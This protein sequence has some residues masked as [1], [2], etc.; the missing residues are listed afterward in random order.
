[1]P[2]TT[3]DVIGESK[4]VVTG[5]KFD[6]FMKTFW[7]LLITF[8]ALPVVAQ[9]TEP[10]IATATGFKFTAADLPAETAE[11]YRGLSTKIAELRLR[12]LDEE[13]ANTLFELEAKS[14]NLT[15]E[16]Y[17]ADLRA[18][19]PD[20]SEADLKAIYD[21]NRAAIGDRDLASIRPQ[22]VA[23]LREEPETKVL[24]AKF[25]QLK[26]KYK[27]TPGKDVNGVSLRP[28]DVLVTIGTK[29][30]T[31]Q[32]FEDRN[33]VTLYEAKAKVFDD[34]K[35]ALGEVL[36]TALVTAESKSLGMDSSDFLAREISDKLRDFS[37]DERAALE[38]ALRK[39]LFA[40][41]KTQILL[42]EP[43]PLVFDISVADAPVKGPATA[44][45]TVVMFSDFQCSH[46]AATHPMVTRV[47]AE[48]G[49]KI[50]FAVRD[51]PLES[52][53]PDAFNAARAANAAK[54]QGKFFDY[55]EILYKN[56]DAQSVAQL[57]NY[58]SELGLNLKQFELDFQSAANA[59]AVR[60]D[61]ADGKSYGITAT[62]TI[63]VNGVK[64]RVPTADGIREAIDK[65]LRK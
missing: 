11:A 43:T 21:A 63:F 40:K 65:A 56:Q 58:A 39:R 36:Y 49:D 14:K 16:K 31:T 4:I 64:V 29:A 19:V 24:R 54:A 9:T 30:I 23:F 17:V 6:T 53:H 46:C 22:L 15:V 61:L 62:P 44:P 38:S 47:L 59:A 13:I 10:A 5:L 51:F 1:M 7:L 57:K 26:T 20:P 48:Y 18:T 37:A 27:I 60:K 8:F 32:D 34:V 33:R 12:L 2:A 41:Y 25:D 50:R 3:R 28:V 45:V 52:I 42:K 35:S 55:L